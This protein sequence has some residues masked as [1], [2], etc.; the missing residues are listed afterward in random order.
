MSVNY[1]VTEYKAFVCL[2]KK[3][4]PVSVWVL[5]KKVPDPQNYIL[6]SFSRTVFGM[7]V[8]SL[9]NKWVPGDSWIADVDVE[10]RSVVFC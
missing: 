9:R 10:K 2:W 3:I 8:S 4:V 7:Q 5:L 6:F 1:F